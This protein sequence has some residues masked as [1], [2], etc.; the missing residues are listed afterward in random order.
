M[1][2]K[3]YHCSFQ[4]YEERKDLVIKWKLFLGFFLFLVVFV[5]PISHLKNGLWWRKGKGKKKT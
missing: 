1:L 4:N 3:V 2:Y 5:F